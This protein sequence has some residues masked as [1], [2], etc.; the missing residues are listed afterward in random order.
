MCGW[1]DVARSGFLGRSPLSPLRQMIPP[2]ARSTTV[3]PGYST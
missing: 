3:P 1:L 2:V